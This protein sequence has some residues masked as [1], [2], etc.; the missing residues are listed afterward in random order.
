MN[1]SCSRVPRPAAH[2]SPLHL[3]PPPHAEGPPAPRALQ[4]APAAGRPALPGLGLEGARCP[5]PQGSCRPPILAVVGP[6]PASPALS[7]VQLCAPPASV[8]S[9]WEA[10]PPSHSPKLLCSYPGGVPGPT[11]CQAEMPCSN[12]F[13]PTRVSRGGTGTNFPWTSRPSGVTTRPPGRSR[14]GTAAVP[15]G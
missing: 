5:M 14:R 4:L 2:K 8:L 9:P 1:L 10:L 7:E 12:L 15:P 11:L 6:L 3:G 13:A